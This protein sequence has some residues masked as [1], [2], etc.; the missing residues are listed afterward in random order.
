MQTQIRWESLA[1]PFKY[2]KP[3]ALVFVLREESTE[4]VWW[5]KSQG[6]IS[7]VKILGNTVKIIVNSS[8]FERTRKIFKDS[9][10]LTY[11]FLEEHSFYEEYFEMI[12]DSQGRCWC[13]GRGENHDHAGG[14]D[15]VIN[16]FLFD[17]LCSGW[18]EEHLCWEPGDRSRQNHQVNIEWREWGVL[19]SSFI[20]HIWESY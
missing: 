12:W 20:P 1:K 14:Q 11:G 4:Q 3:F 19:G 2:L 9:C 13:W 18:R 16:T 7:S 6:E 5:K 8:P 17:W 10:E 15:N